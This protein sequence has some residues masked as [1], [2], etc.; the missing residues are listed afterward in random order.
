MP[1]SIRRGLQ[2]GFRQTPFS[3]QQ[4]VSLISRAASLSWV[5]ENNMKASS[6]K[7]NFSKR[8]DLLGFRARFFA[9]PAPLRIS[10]AIT[11]A[12]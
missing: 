2:F 8:L 11:K 4:L 6:V 9:E 10:T 12:C 5:G 3:F 7:E 1:C